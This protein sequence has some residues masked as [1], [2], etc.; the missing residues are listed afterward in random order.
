MQGFQGPQQAVFLDVAVHQAVPA[1]M[2]QDDVP[3]FSVTSGIVL[4]SMQ[5]Y[6]TFMYCCKCVQL[7]Y[8]DSKSDD[9]N[10]SQYMLGA[11]LDVSF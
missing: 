5:L 7:E 3:L 6:N 8:D 11:S 10:S 2:L 1:S 9:L 4:L